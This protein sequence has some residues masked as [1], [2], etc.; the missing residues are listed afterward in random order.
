MRTRIGEGF[1]EL[2]A[3]A[4]ENSEKS[5][6]WLFQQ[7]KWLLLQILE[8][9]K[10]FLN[11]FYHFWLFHGLKQPFDLFVP[12]VNFKQ[13]RLLF[14]AVP[15]DICPGYFKKKFSKKHL[16]PSHFLLKNFMTNVFLKCFWNFK[17]N[18][19]LKRLWMPSPE[20][21][22]RTHHTRLLVILILVNF[23]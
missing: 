11:H 21:S 13:W 8:V 2:Y 4:Q 5:S 16:W 14:T 12:F 3:F 17:K 19:F 20:K 6:T 7:R 1:F 10:E 18:S 23:F 15:Y 22:K 9:K